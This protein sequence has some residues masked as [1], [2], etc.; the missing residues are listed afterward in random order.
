[1]RHPDDWNTWHRDY[2]TGSRYDCLWCPLQ[3]DTAESQ[4]RLELFKPAF[5]QLVALICGR[6]RYPDDW[7]TWHRDDKDDFMLQRYSVGDTLLDAT[8]EGSTADRC[9]LCV[10]WEPKKIQS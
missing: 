5:S 2:V 10:F 1:M 4:R 6:V 8:G 3:D 7:D 9:V